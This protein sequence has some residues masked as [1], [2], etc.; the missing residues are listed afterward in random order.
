[1]SIT[2]LDFDLLIEHHEDRYRARVINSPAG[3]AM[4][5][6]VQPFSPLEL[7]NFVLT[8]KDAIGD[9]AIRGIDSPQ[10][11]RI[12]AF[13]GKLYES[14]FADEVG[15]TLRSSLDEA[16]H[17]DSGLRLRLHLDDVPELADLP[18]EYLYHRRLNRFLARSPETPVVRYLDI[19][20]RIRPL[21]VTPPMKVFVVISSPSDYRRLDVEREWSKLETAL[22]ALQKRNLV[23]LDRVG[24]A[25]LRGLRR[26]L[27]TSDC[28]ILHFIGHGGFD[29]DAQDGV[30]VFEDEA[31][32]GRWV[33]G[34]YLGELLRRPRRP[35]R[36][37]I[38]NACEG[39][40]GAVMDPYAGA[41]QSMVQQGIPAVIAMQFAITDE[42][43]ITFTSDF[44]EA[45]ADGYP[46]DASLAEARRAVFEA[47][48]ELEWATP[49]LYM[50][51]PDGVIF[52]VTEVPPEVEEGRPRALAEEDARETAERERV[53]RAARE[54]VEGDESAR[55]AAQRAARVRAM[56]GMA[57]QADDLVR[58]GESE[59]ALAKCN[60]VLDRI[61]ASP[62]LSPT[63]AKVQRVTA[64]ALSH[65]GRQ[66]EALAR[67]DEI[68]AMWG[69]S[70]ASELRRQVATASVRRGVAL[71]QMDRRDDAI[72]AFDDVVRR[73]GDSRDPAVLAEVQ[74]ARELAEQARHQTDRRRLI[75][76]VL[77][78]AAVAVLA[79][80]GIFLVRALGGNQTRWTVT[81]LG[82]DDWK[83]T[84]AEC[85]G[86]DVFDITATGR[87]FHSP[88]R[89]TGP[90]GDPDPRLQSFSVMQEENHAGLI[91]SF[92]RA[93]PY[94]WVG[95]AQRSLA[96]PSAGSLFLGINDMGVDKNRGMFIARIVKRSPSG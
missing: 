96:C 14:V 49:V 7:E 40:R 74:S 32:R 52:D 71:D 50:R 11:A 3:P 63:Y 53:E 19:P 44:Y 20:E 37:A 57:D 1:M 6:F 27:H 77:I 47:E 35:T 4:A 38:L 64:D 22:G 82:T 8:I 16:G 84:G 33:S 88:N 56:A 23:E 59:Q 41:A 25:T 67:Y 70:S 29:K 45:L 46:V 69:D 39:A 58:R 78:A 42:A 55:I 83:A 91:G 26:K 66:E 85:K 28:H 2:Y 31:G 13:G 60:E 10:T 76:W 62:E 54:A 21:K 36:L 79:V 24:P 86:G 89:S 87:V 17:R 43:A 51:S 18:W 95:A 34:Q 15:E 92:D 65:L 75:R 61:D 72:A 94:F 73:F 12:K 68:L 30:L 81:V 90:D 80:A 9:P 48:F 5:D 93:P